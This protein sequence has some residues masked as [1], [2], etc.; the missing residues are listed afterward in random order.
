MITKILKKKHFILNGSFTFFLKIKKVG[1][2]T[3]MPFKNK[4]KVKILLKL[5]KILVLITTLRIL[6]PAHNSSSQ[7]LC[8]FY[9]KGRR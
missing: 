1:R 6:F 5:R 9:K 3:R 2:K 8:N 4:E 7:M